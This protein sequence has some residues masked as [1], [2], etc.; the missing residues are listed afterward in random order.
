MWNMSV[1]RMFQTITFVFTVLVLMSPI[2]AQ[3]APPAQSATP[4]VPAGHAI[5]FSAAAT[6]V[7]IY[8]C[9]ATTQTWGYERR[10]PNC[11]NRIC[12]LGLG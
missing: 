10:A 11:V 8:E 1:R 2:A 4:Q 6:G 3:A 7:Q 9:Q 5:L 12:E